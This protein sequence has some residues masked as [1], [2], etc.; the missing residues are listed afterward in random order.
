MDR[1]RVIVAIYFGLNETSR[2]MLLS[3]EYPRVLTSVDV[4]YKH[5]S[6]S[7]SSYEGRTTIWEDPR[8]IQ[9]WPVTLNEGMIH[10]ANS[11]P[12]VLGYKYDRNG[13]VVDFKVGFEFTRLKYVGEQYGEWQERRYAQF[14]DRKEQCDDAMGIEEQSSKSRSMPSHDA[15]ITWYVHYLTYIY[16]W[17]KRILGEGIHHILQEKYSRE[18]TKIAGFA[19]CSVSFLFGVPTS[20]DEETRSLFSQTATQAGFGHEKGH[21]AEIAPSRI[22]CAS[23]YALWMWNAEL[24]YDMGLG[25][26]I[27]VCATDGLGTTV[28]W[29]FR[30]SYQTY[31][32]CSE[33]TLTGPAPVVSD[34]V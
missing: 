13:K 12:C 23:A 14:L 17:I 18:D 22:E 16:S 2:L 15:V 3:S 27:I 24:L 33:K 19:G 6:S 4:C 34:R 5:L 7:D 31:N 20:W 32:R 29:P 8:V 11:I 28:R 26:H 21:T 30:N 10:V 25:G 9:Y 1:D